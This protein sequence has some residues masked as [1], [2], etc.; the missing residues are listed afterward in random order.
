MAAVTR[1]VSVQLPLPGKYRLA[2]LKLSAPA[3]AVS[4]GAADSGTPLQVVLIFDGLA[5]TMPAG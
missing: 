3:V 4:T 1:T 2:A 5:L